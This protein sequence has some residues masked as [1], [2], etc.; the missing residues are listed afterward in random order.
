MGLVV[1]GCWCR[2]RGVVPRGS[3]ESQGGHLSE[4]AIYSG[5]GFEVGYW[6][7]LSGYFDR[8]KR[9]LRESRGTSGG[10][11]KKGGAHLDTFLPLTS[12]VRMTVVRG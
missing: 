12:I 5:V 1:R 6:R 2:G 10:V 8:E 4:V 3:R 9:E 11:F 7:G